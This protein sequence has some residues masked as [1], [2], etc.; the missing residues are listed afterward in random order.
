MGFLL[1]LD[2]VTTK[3]IEE[4]LNQDLSVQIQSFERAQQKSEILTES[5]HAQKS[6][7]G[8]LIITIQRMES[9]LEELK[10]QVSKSFQNTDALRVNISCKNFFSYIYAFL[11]FFIYQL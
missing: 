4:T 2:W 9:T 8:L 10:V 7:S 3:N 5:I 6:E 1:T 11:S